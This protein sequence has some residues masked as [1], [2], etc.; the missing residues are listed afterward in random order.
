MARPRKPA[1]PPAEIR[2]APEVETV[3][4]KLIGLYHRGIEGCRI[5]FAFRCGDWKNK[6]KDV[7]G[8]ASVISGT[9]AYMAALG[10]PIEQRKAAKLF[11]V[12]ISKA[13]WERFSLAQREALV[14]HELCHLWLNAKGQ[15]STVGHDLEEFKAIVDRHG[16]WLGDIEEFATVAAHKLEQLSLPMAAMEAE[17]GEEPVGIG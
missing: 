16:F 3:G 5:E 17:M 8:K 4:R 9:G 6:G 13:A 10:L 15:P 1:K 7:F 11:L 14:D 12:L 2:P